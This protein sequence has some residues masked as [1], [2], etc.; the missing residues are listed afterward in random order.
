MWTQNNTDH[1]NRSPIRNVSPNAQSCVC[2]GS[3]RSDP[4]S[5][6]SVLVRRGVTILL[7]AQQSA[8]FSFCP[9]IT[10]NHNH[11]SY[12]LS[13][14]AKGCLSVDNARRR[15]LFLTTSY[16]LTPDAVSGVFVKRLVGSLQKLADIQVITPDDN[17]T[18]SPP[19]GVYSF[20]Y[21]PKKKQLMAHGFGGIP[22]ALGQSRFNYVYAFS[23]VV[24]FFLVTLRK[25]TSYHI[26]HANWSIPG[27][28]AGVAG[29]ITGKP[30]LTTLRGEDITRAKTSYLFK[31]M[32]HSCLA[33]NRFVVCV[34]SDMQADLQAMFP[35][36][37]SKIMHIPNG[38]DPTF[39]ASKDKKKNHSTIQLLCI[40]SLIPRKNF[41]CV[42]QAISQSRHL[43]II[44]LTIAGD[45]P[46]RL[47][48]EALATKLGIHENVRF[49]GSI[50]PEKV[51]NLYQNV[52]IFIIPSH[53]E[54]RPNVLLEAMAAGLP[55]LASN[56]SGIT[57]LVEEDFSGYL[58]YPHE[59]DTLCILIDRL[60]SNPA[61]RTRLGNNARLRIQQ[62]NTCWKTT[63]DR[64]HQLYQL[65][66]E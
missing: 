1:R 22:A 34:S 5:K 64:Y 13:P 49:L 47:Q 20:R 2:K 21:A 11:A 16:P 43:K 56:I 15:V 53:S 4:P 32:L 23:L 25:C 29:K 66:T 14:I 42:L 58:F 65:M 9:I 60:I 36:F 18:I 61:N 26:L 12:V 24:C 63:A 52:D 54:G 8:L 3:N 45:G 50:P 35:R 27:V 28:I 38:V 31:A 10:K 37:R 30:V 33:L 51:A 39:A 6:S 41:A 46:E 57:E 59:S 19:D 55:I 17:K 44:N 40:G 48:L 62:E 7:F